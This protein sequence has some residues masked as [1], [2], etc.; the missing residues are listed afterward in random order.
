M[1]FKLICCCTIGFGW[2]YFIIGAVLDNWIVWRGR[3]R[4]SC[5]I[6]ILLPCLSTT[7]TRLVTTIVILS[8]SE[9][10]SH[11]VILAKTQDL[12]RAR[13]REQAEAFSWLHSYCFTHLIF[14]HEVPVLVTH[15]VVSHLHSHL[16][17]HSCGHLVTHMF[18]ELYSVTGGFY[19]YF[20]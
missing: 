4:C 17:N 6:I 7:L 2:R 16:F 18:T 11:T 5:I 15:H 13:G 19:Y 3:C 9:S 12:R 10:L 8:C 14:Y 20:K 1:T